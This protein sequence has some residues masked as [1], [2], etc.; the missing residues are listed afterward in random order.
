[1]KFPKETL[2]DALVQEVR[3]GSLV[4]DALG[5]QQVVRSGLMTSGEMPRVA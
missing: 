5:D 2:A 1:L 3:E 4:A